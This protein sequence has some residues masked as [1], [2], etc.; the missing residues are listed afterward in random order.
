MLY[1]MLLKKL[2]LTEG[3]MMSQ[4]YSDMDHM[5]RTQHDPTIVP[6]DQCKIAK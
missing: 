2:N 3:S 4:Q 5:S 6:D 1:L